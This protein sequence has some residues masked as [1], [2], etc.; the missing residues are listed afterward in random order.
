MSINRNK[1]ILIDIELDYVLKRR[2]E[3]NKY[4]VFMANK[5]T[6][7]YGF[8]KKK[9]VA[10]WLCLIE[11]SNKEIASKSSVSCGLIRKWKTEDKFKEAMRMNKESIRTYV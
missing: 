8:S 2:E 10:S 3:V 1:I 11:L 6:N 5:N 9:Y 7:P 4:V